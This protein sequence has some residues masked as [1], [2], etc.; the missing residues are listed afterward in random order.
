MSTIACSPVCLQ[1]KASCTPCNTE[2]RDLAGALPATTRYRSR[3]FDQTSFSLRAPA[4]ADRERLA[5]LPNQPTTRRSR[6]QSNK[7]RCL[8]LQREHRTLIHSILFPVEEQLMAWC[9]CSRTDR[10]CMLWQWHTGM[11][12][13][14]TKWLGRGTFVLWCSSS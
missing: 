2:A 14:A 13:A 11:T 5:K 4:T 6:Q 1:L 3:H 10:I 9:Y 12:A 7:P 8:C